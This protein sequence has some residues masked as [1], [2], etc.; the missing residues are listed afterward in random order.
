MEKL[1]K[2]TPFHRSDLVP[3]GLFSISQEPSATPVP[4]PRHSSHPDSTVNMASSM[5]VDLPADEEKLA[6]QVKRK[7]PEN[8]DADEDDEEDE[9]HCELKLEEIR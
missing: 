2:G 1:F 9:L 8:G 3:S 5:V 4:E 6:P 7:A